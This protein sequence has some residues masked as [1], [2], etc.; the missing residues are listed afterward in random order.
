MN[1]EKSVSRI[2]VETYV[3]DALRKIRNDPERGIRN[4]VDM[5]LQFSGGRFRYDFLSTVRTMLGNESSAY[6]RLVK[7]I[8][9][10]VDEDRLCTFG[11]NL[12]YNGCTHGAKCI[13]KNEE[14]MGL[15]IPWSVV[16]ELDPVSFEDDRQEYLSAIRDGE[17]LGIYVWILGAME[18]PGNALSL[19]G[20]YPEGAFFILCRAEDLTAA[21]LDKAAE[22]DNTMF[23]LQYGEDISKTCEAMRRRNLMYSVWYQYGGDDTGCIADGSLFLRAQELSPAFTVLLPAPGCTEKTREEV[24]QEVQRVRKSQIY[25]TIVWELVEDS[26]MVD[27]VISGDPCFVCFDGSGNLSSPDGKNSGGVQNLFRSGLLK[28]LKD[29]FPKNRK[30]KQDRG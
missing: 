29:N 21:F 1:M 12:G 13:R 15:N 4:L 9:G 5:A 30:T 10:Y 3:R 2:L 24:Y 8:V 23:V 25:H 6:Y 7:D 11:M 19:A 22:S 26:R 16:C 20:Q 17:S 27:S 28:I 18:N 14:E